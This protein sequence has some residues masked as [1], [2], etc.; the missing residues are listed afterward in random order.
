MSQDAIAC[1]RPPAHTAR[2]TLAKARRSAPPLTLADI[3]KVRRR[4]A[5]EAMSRRP[6][7]WQLLT[8]ELDNQ[9]RASVHARYSVEP[10]TVHMRAFQVYIDPGSLGP[11]DTK[12]EG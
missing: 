8:M 4:L 5:Q 3:Q 7:D 10:P 12:P 6:T 1:F 9:L 2:Y 11:V